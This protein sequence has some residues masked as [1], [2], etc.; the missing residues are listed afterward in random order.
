MRFCGDL[1][2]DTA[3]KQK[4]EDRIPELARL[5]LYLQG[6]KKQCNKVPNIRIW[7]R[8]IDQTIG[9]LDEVVGICKAKTSQGYQL[10]VKNAL[11]IQHE[12]VDEN[13][14][15]SE[16]DKAKYGLLIAILM[17]IYM[18]HRPGSL[19]YAVSESS[20]KNFLFSFRPNTIVLIS[21]STKEVGVIENNCFGN[22]ADLSQLLGAARWLAFTKETD[23]SGCETVTYEW[24]PRAKSVINPMTILQAY[25]TMGGSAPHHW[26]LHYQEAQFVSRNG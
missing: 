6:R 22:Q 3:G 11:K 2:L 17:F 4:L 19:N 26:G 12:T 15:Y 25:C 8:C 7:E 14:Y 21:L 23:E 24:G 18:M 16:E 5:I 13:C 10:Y 9:I 20:I 1:I